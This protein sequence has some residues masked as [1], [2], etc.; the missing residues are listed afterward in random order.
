MSNNKRGG[1]SRLNLKQ[2]I[3]KEIG[4]I[5]KAD[6]YIYISSRNKLNRSRL[7]QKLNLLRLIISTGFPILMKLAILGS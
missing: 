5:G 7:M 3:R 2:W 4:L 1:Q 6:I